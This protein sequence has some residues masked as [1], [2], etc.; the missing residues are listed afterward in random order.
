MN[1]WWVN[2]N[3]T[4]RQE[5][6]GGYM[7]SPKQN[8]NGAKNHHYD[9]MLRVVPGDL[10]FSFRDRKIPSVG[11]ATS[12]AYS[13]PKPAEFGAAGRNWDDDGWRVHVDY[14]DPNTIIRPVDHMAL[15][16]PTLPEDRSPLYANGDGKQ[17]Y[18]FHVPAAMAAALSALIGADA[19]TIATAAQTLP[20][21]DSPDSSAGSDA[22]VDRIQNAT[23]I[24]E[25]EKEA[26]IK[27]RRGQGRF[28]TN[29]FLYETR[30][31]VSGISNADYLIASHIKPWS[32][33]SN[34]E[35]LN[36]AN[37]LALSAHIDHL[38]DKGYISFTD[39]GDIICSPLVDSSVLN[40]LHVD[41]AMNVGPFHAQ[42]LPYLAYHREFRLKH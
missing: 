16:G 38:F 27:A 5:R 26:L 40:Q 33:S 35:R 7:W 13:S 39:A 36:G 29:V 10:I 37:G 14:R 6:D 23:D 32:Q 17:A 28:R 4:Y 31:R 3:Q 30:C 20:L 1:Y 42:Q 19:A 11:I 22:V 25:T 34:S 41:P 21:P 9:N 15:L 12:F 2:Q 24:P 18:L 8:A